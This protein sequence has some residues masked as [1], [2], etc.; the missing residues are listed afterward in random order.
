MSYFDRRIRGILATVYDD[1]VNNNLDTTSLQS[2]T[3]RYLKVDPKDHDTHLF[4][5]LE[6]NFPDSGSYT[7]KGVIS[8]EF[9]NW[10]VATN[11]SIHIRTNGVKDTDFYCRW[12]LLFESSNSDYH[13][14]EKYINMGL[15]GCLTGVHAKW[16]MEGDRKKAVLNMWL[17]RKQCEGKLKKSRVKDFRSFILDEHANIPFNDE[18]KTA[19]DNSL[20]VFNEM[21]AKE[22]KGQ[23]RLKRARTEE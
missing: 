15:P 20:T 10:L 11:P 2:F 7:S 3:D 19:L 8:K 23:K 17:I 9:K 13:F 1:A 14:V 22:G 6:F 4:V 16:Q 18:Y 5:T 12:G 21:A